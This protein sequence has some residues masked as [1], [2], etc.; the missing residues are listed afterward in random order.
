MFWE[1]EQSIKKLGQ[2]VMVWV[3]GIEI[4]VELSR[5]SCSDLSLVADPVDE[6]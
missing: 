6:K 3:T 2:E 5:R 1:V 4:S